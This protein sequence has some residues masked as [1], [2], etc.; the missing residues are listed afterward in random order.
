M[1]EHRFVGEQQELI[2]GE[3][4]WG[5]DFGNERREPVNSVRNFIGLSLQLE[6]P[7]VL[8][9]DILVAR[10]FPRQ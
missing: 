8:S 5:G 4:R 6:P 1:K 7:R 10:T 3:T 9:T 2:E